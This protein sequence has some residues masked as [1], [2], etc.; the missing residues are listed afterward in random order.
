ML[1]WLLF[2]NTAFVV[3]LQDVVEPIRDEILSKFVVDIHA[4]S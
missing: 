1:I 4:K 3:N 2:V